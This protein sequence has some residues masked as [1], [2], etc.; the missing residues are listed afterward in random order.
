MAVTPEELK[1]PQ[2][3]GQLKDWLDRLVRG[4]IRYA[5]M[6]WGPPGIGKSSIVQQV[7]DAHGMAM[8]DVRLSQLAPTDLRGLPVPDLETEKAKW[9]PPD[10]LPRSG[11]GILFLDEMNMA[12][13]V[14]QGIAQQLILDRKV[15]SY[16]V[17]D[18]WFIW[19]AGNRRE[20]RAT[21][22]DMPAPLANRF[23][24]M[25]VAPDLDSFRKYG[26]ENGIAE[27]ILAFLSFRSP[28]LHKMSKTEPAWP[29]PRSWAMAS[30]MH[31]NKM[32]IDSAVGEATG[33]EFYGFLDTYKKL[34][35]IDKILAGEGENEA[36]PLEPSARYATTMALVVRPKT[37][38]EVYNG[39]KWMSS[40]T[41]KPRSGEEFRSLLF[42]NIMSAMKGSVKTDFAKIY[43]KDKD[44]T[45]VISR[46]ISLQG[47][48]LS[49][50]G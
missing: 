31:L 24:H 10:F 39:M 22:F 27:E 20:D 35:D 2:T 4:Q 38:L 33:V 30:T 32:N 37:G 17:P 12:P 23:L 49:R 15:G 48:K 11:K 13:P 50:A 36:W 44:L 29:S 26:V 21:V 14:V 7:A 16:V 34:P 40:P 5:A 46:M 43:A 1:A 47:S 28:L 41:D 6:I 8:S 25:D 3:P 9:F 45:K 18:G 19:A 42:A